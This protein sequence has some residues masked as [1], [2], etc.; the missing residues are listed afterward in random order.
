MKLNYTGIIAFTF[1]L[2]LCLNKLSHAQ[3][4]VE[5]LFKA[6]PSDAGKLIG[7]YLSPLQKGLGT[8]LNSGW[9]HTAKTKGFLRFEL[10]I[11]V[12]GAQV[13]TGDRT[14]D[15][16][17][18]NLSNIRPVNPAFTTGPT[19]FGDD[20]EGAE[21]EVYSGTTSITRFNLPQGLGFN[22]V[23]TPQIQATVGVHKNVD[24]MVRYVPS[25]KI[26]DDEGKVDMFG[27]GAKVE[28]LPLIMGDASDKVPV[29]VAASF[30]FSKVN[31]TLPIDVSQGKYQ[32]Q[33]IESTFNGYHFEAIVSKKLAFFT[34]FVSLGYQT[35][36]SK[37]DALGT[38]EFYNGNPPAITVSNDPIKLKQADFSGLRTSV[39]FQLK[40]AFFKLYGSYT[41]F[42]YNTINAGISFGTG[43]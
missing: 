42:G 24:L 21:M 37:L 8:G 35:S 34:P 5:D 23:P 10:R 26:S 4:H 3:T 1:I 39:G 40:L 15:V 30:G 13:P 9:T 7:A 14:F 19:A 32:N 28:A 36:D 41:S 25:I 22:I 29:D 18:L 12:A 20:R 2:T 6:N 27:A 43:N 38:Y 11:S 31:F 33:R 16:R 17:G